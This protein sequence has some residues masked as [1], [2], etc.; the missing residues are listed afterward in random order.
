MLRRFFQASGAQVL[1]NPTGS[2][3][4]LRDAATGYIYIKL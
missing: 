1:G 3:A 2:P 4:L